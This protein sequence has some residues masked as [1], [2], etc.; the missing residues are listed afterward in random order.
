[1]MPTLDVPR[2][3]RNAT[4]SDLVDLLSRQADVRYDVVVPAARVRSVN[5]TL[6]VLDG[7]A[8]F[9]GDEPRVADLWAR[10][11]AVCDE[12]IAARTGIPIAYLRR[13]R[14]EPKAT[15][16]LDHNVNHWLESDP[17]RRVFLRM[18]HDGSPGTI[19]VARALL[20]DRYAPV[21][22]YDVLLAVLDGIR[23]AGIDATVAGGD[24]TDRRMRVRI[25]APEVTAAAPWLLDRYRAPDGRRGADYPLVSAG[26][27][28]ENS[29][30]GGGAF[31]IV[32]RLVVQVCSNG[33]VVSRDALRKVHLG[34]RLD[35]GVIVWS[36]DTAQ[37]NIALIAAQ[38]RDA[39]TT[40]LDRDYLTRTLDSF[41]DAATT[42]LDYPNETMERVLTPLGY[43]QAQRDA[44]LGHF[45]R[46]GDTTAGG[47]AQA[48]TALAREVDDADL[49]ARLEDQALDALVAAAA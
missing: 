22:N 12:G 4:L 13:M 2:D 18:F 19:G 31:T 5:G 41:R 37:Q 7:A 28:V 45:I 11:T 17:A 42:A 3:A 10:P 21:D 20:S 24:V 48:M 23:A 35:D 38:A 29:E 32:P 47:L 15:T 43:S 40:F 26:L 1:M 8:H 34:A 27:A 33:L 9:D 44:I 30:T 46:G 6:A 25:E 49:S 16:L 14:D 36:E 39:V